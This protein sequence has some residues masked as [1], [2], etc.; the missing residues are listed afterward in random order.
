VAIARAILKNPRILILDD[1][2]SSVDTE[3]ETEIR[4]ALEKLMKNRT[5]FIIAHRVQSVMNADLILVLDKGLVIQEGTHQELLE[6]DG[7]YRQIYDIQTRI[8]I[9]IENE[10]TWDE[11]EDGLTYAAREGAAIDIAP[12]SAMIETAYDK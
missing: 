8:E 5:T 9:E 6:Q 2:T 12:E 11:A 10:I 1:S 4:N 3:T 7:V